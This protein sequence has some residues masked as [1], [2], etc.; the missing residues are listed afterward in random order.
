MRKE[1]RGSVGAKQVPGTP[2]K[3]T[4]VS[5]HRSDDHRRSDDLAC[6]EFGETG[7]R[8]LQISPCMCKQHLEP[9]REIKT[10]GGQV[11]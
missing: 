10:W 4:T 2:E 8:R 6:G 5:H 9:Q 7:K 11:L 1:G 3:F